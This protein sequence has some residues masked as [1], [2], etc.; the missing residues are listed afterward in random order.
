LLTSK[1]RAYLRKLANSMD[2]ILQIGKHGA[3]PELCEALNEAL[4]ARELV[5]VSVLN[6]CAEAPKDMVE[7]ICKSTR[8]ECVQLIGK[9]IVFFRRNRENPMIVL[10]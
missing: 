6:N 4:E 8:S 7:A 2:A 1:Q 3:A 10:P 9:K 5:K